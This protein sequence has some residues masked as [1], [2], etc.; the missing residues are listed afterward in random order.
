MPVPRMLL[1]GA[2]CAL[3]GVSAALAAAEEARP[4][5]IRP[6]PELPESLP[7]DL[8]S[9]SQPPAVEWLDDTAPVRS[10]VFAGEPF[11]GRATRVFAYVAT[12]AS[13]G[14]ERGAA[15]TSGSSWPGVVLVHGGGGTAFAEWV[16]LWASRGYAAIAMDL[17]GR[18]PDPKAPRKPAATRLPDGG[19]GQELPLVAAAPRSAP[20][21]AGVA[22]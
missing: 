15:A 12:P 8:A 20:M 11:R 4:R 10:L 3:L 14:A 2:C 9:L 16:K 7:W 18:R 5:P 1:A 19:P 17:A 13:I 22:T 21:L 6:A